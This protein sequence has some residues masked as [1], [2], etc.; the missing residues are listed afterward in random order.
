MAAG[1]R[2]FAQEAWVTLERTEATCFLSHLMYPWQDI[3]TSASCVVQSIGGHG[4]GSGDP[5]AHRSPMISAAA[6]AR[7]VT[8]ARA[9]EN[10]ILYMTVIPMFLKFLLYG[11]S[12]KHAVSLSHWTWLHAV[13]VHV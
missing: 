12:T 11:V 8:N 9:L 1:A 7:N 4:G 5:H 13:I 10:G 3:D 6:A 2:S